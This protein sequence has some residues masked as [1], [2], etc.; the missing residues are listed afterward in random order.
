MD[1]LIFLAILIA[2]VIRIWIEKGYFLLPKVYTK[3]GKTYFQ[4]N[5]IG[6]ICTALITVLILY[7]AQPELFRTFIGALITA[8]TIPHLFDNVVSKAIPN[9][10]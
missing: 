7:Q 8:Y 9:E 6:T 1:L 5:I 4:L 2:I 3:S 10:E